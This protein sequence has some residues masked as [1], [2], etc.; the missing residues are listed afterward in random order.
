MIYFASTSASFP[1]TSLK[2]VSQKEAAFITTTTRVNQDIMHM[3]HL[4]SNIQ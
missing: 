4:Q 1:L 2:D 3:C